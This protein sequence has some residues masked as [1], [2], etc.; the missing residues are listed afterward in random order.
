M[1]R[2]ASG[3][4]LLRPFRRA[5]VALQREYFEDPELAWLDSN[6]PAGYAEIDLGELMDTEAASDRHIVALGIEVDGRYVGFCRL[7][8]TADPNRVFQLGINIGDRR[9][10]NRGFGRV[11]IRLLL[12]HGFDALGAEAIEL[13]TNSKNERGIACFAACGFVEQRRTPKHIRYQSEWA[14]MIEMSIDRSRW[15]SV[16]ASVG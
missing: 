10:W 6:S 8:N 5:D 4:V 14:D 2:L 13:T 3:P 16:T 11:V 1:T 15:R 9:Y 12:A 7:L